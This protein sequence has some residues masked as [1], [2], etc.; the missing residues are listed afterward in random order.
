VWQA[1]SVRPEL[2]GFILVGGSALALHLNHR[3]SEDLDF[4]WPQPRLPREALRQLTQPGSDLAFDSRQ[5]PRAEREASDCGFDLD[6]SSQNYFV[7]QLVK[8]TFFCPDAPE[9]M[10]LSQTP[11]SGL[12]IAT[13]AEI[14]AMKALV[15]AKRS[16][17]RDWFDLY[18][19][20]KHHGFSWKDFYQAF[21]ETESE[22][23]YDYAAERLTRAH[24]SKSDEGYEALLPNP[25]TIEEMRA[26]FLQRRNSYE[27]GREC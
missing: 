15:S 18:V 26:F 19:L 20:M 27:Q 17:A 5:D 14:F 3:I 16:K 24:P 6:D 8:V 1:L 4:V 11:G 12:R 21:V 7:N 2:D 25:P 13:L 9:R 10:I 22:G 23:Q